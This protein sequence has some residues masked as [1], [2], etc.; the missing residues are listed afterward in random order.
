MYSPL[1]VLLLPSK[2][3]VNGLVF[4]PMSVQGVKLAPV[5]NSPFS[6]NTPLLMVMSAVSLALIELLTVFT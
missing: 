4:V 2:V 1:M 3:P 6:F 5:C